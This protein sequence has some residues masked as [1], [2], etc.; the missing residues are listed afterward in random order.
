[1]DENEFFREATLR[2]CGNLE[3]EKA[4][5]SA[6]KYMRQVMPVDH[7]FFQFYDEEHNAMHILADASPECGRIVDLQVKLSV[8]AR[9][10]LMQFREEFRHKKSKFVWLFRDNPRKQKLTDEIFNSLGYSTISLMVFPLGLKFQELLG[11]G[12]LILSSES[13]SKFSQQHVEL[14]SLV[15]EPFAIAL[16]NALKHRSELKLYDRDFFWE[17]TTRICGNLEIE[18]GLRSCLELL[19]QYMPADSLYLERHERNFGAMHMIARATADKSEKMDVLIPFTEEGKAKMAMLAQEWIKGTFPSVLVINNP[20]EEPVTKHL[21][22]T[23]GEPPSSVMS[24]PLFLKD[25]IAG[26]LVVIAEGDNRFSEQHAKLYS[27]LRMPFFVA[28]SNTLKH[29][30]IIKLKDLLADDNRYLQGELRRL[31]GDEIVGA[32]FGLRDVMYKV[33]Q[34]VALNSPVLLLGETGVGKDVI[35]QTIHYSSSRSDG[36]FVS[37]NCGAI[38]ESL[39][40]SELFGHEEG[41]FTGA[42]TQKRGRFERANKGTIFLDE[43][44]ELPLQAQVRLLRVLQSKEIERVGGVETIPLDIRIIAATNRNLEEMVAQNT[45]REDLWFRLNV[46]PIQIPPLRERKEDIPALL[47]YFIRQKTKELNLPAVPSIFPGAIDFLLSYSWPGNVRELGNIVERAMILSPAG[48]LTF[49]HLNPVDTKKNTEEMPSHQREQPLDLDSVISRHIRSVLSQTDGKVN[50]EDG[51]AALLG[52]NP[53][54]LRNR[55][56]KLGIPYGKQRYL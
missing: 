47:Q 30:E 3:I 32:N 11:G 29:R 50:G 55:M 45:F 25:E 37:V 21:L 56:K 28:V 10:E 31:S 34:V 6:L 27:N 22:K 46:F 41:A 49:D 23:L 7:M 1:M 2:I 13:E 39:I 20:R 53:S 14:L 38:P 44:G 48:P 12:S 54:T 42:V 43:I 40:D 26:A 24:L 5:F 52:V 18:E 36:P 4:L 15:R 35:A 19:S 9:Q 17:I 33:Q 16:S 51:A 8:G